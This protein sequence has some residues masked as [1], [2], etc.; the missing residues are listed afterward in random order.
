MNY[1]DKTVCVYS[2]GMDMWMAERLT[3][4]FGRVLL[5]TPWTS[6]YPRSQDDRIGTGI[7]EVERISDFWSHIDDIDLFIF[8]GLYHGDIQQH[9]VDLG[10]RVWGSR[11][12]DMLERDR[13]G[14]Y[15]KFERLEIPSP[16]MTKV[17]GIDKLREFLKENE[18][19]YIKVSDYRGDFETFC[20][21]NYQL[22]KPVLDELEHR[23][24]LQGINYEFIICYPIDGN[25]I[26]EFGYDGYSIDG[27]F[28]KE[29]IVGY[30][31][32][33]V[34]YCCHVNSNFSPLVTDFT[35]KLSETLKRLKY[36]NFIHSEGRTGKEKIPRIIDTTCRIG[37]PPGEVLCEMLSNL[38]DIFWFGADGELIEPVWEAKYGIQIFIDSSWSENK[39]QAV[40]FPE[41]IARWV[42]LRNYCIDSGTHYVIPKYKD[43]DNI[44]S[45]VAIGNSLD[46]CIEKVSGYSEQIKG[47]KVEI[48][49]ASTDKLKEI[50]KKGEAI[51]ISF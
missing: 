17:K 48:A 50:I 14:A 37:S 1:K 16:E 20:S 34:A 30:E 3:R 39:F 35:E 45:V 13:W 24:G 32:K 36:R 27:K 22:S 38:A 8:L 49:T 23:L 19:V 18:N 4:D 15:K 29:T 46:E 5:F 41:K 33:D 31:H 21:K 7:E 6:D 9:L 26:V 43:F 28:P 11:N 2:D 42:K 51:G 12:G 40:E 10:K 44:G 47:H 25:D